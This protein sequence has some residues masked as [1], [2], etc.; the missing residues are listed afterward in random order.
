MGG[1]FSSRPK[2]DLPAPVPV[3]KEDDAE[4]Q[5]RREEVR[6]AALKRRGRASTILTSGV[7][8]TKKANVKRR[9]LGG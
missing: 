7:G 9:T 5:R 8:D 1:L 2:T 3:P 4:V 6:L